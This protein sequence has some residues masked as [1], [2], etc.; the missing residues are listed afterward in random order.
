MQTTTATLHAGLLARK[1]EA[2]PSAQNEARGSARP[3]HV[4]VMAGAIARREPVTASAREPVV[5]RPA[6]CIELPRSLPAAAPRKPAVAGRR[7]VHARIDDDLHL[8]LR[9]AATRGCR[10]QQSLVASALD[11]Y[12]SSLDE[13]APSPPCGATDARV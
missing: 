13:N 9:I 1:G 6:R 7:Q 3:G 8:R 10:T 2:R 4:T 12:L 5:E 11:A